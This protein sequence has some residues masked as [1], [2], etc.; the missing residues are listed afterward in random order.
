MISV[1]NV[2]SFL[3]VPLAFLFLVESASLR[4]FAIVLA[5]ITDSVDGYLARRNNAVTKFGMILD[6][7]TDKFFVYFAL[8]SLFVEGR[9]SSWQVAAMLSRDI[10]VFAYSLLIL[11]MGR[12]KSIAFRSLWAGKVSTALQF[13]VLIGIVFDLSFSWITYSAFFV[14]GGIA[15]MELFQS[16]KGVWSPFQMFHV[17][18]ANDHRR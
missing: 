12:A 6:P 3:R 7:L 13:I 11:L 8:S 10:A 17:G 9:L 14:M 4:C 5:M 15:F 1:S 2:L 18:S 16:S